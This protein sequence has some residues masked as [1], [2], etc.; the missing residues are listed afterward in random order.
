MTIFVYGDQTEAAKYRSTVEHYLN[1]MTRNFGQTSQSYWRQLSDTAKVHLRLINGQPFA[2]IYTG[3]ALYMESGFLFHLDTQI[4]HDLSYVPSRLYFNSFVSGRTPTT[5]PVPDTALVNPEKTKLLADGDESLA[6]GCKNKVAEFTTYDILGNEYSFSS[7]TPIFCP[8][9][10]DL[11]KAQVS[12]PASVF[13][14]KMRLFIQAIYGSKRTGYYFDET[15][16]PDYPH[17]F[18]LDADLKPVELSSGPISSGLY[19]DPH[20]N[21]WLI[22][23][24]GEIITAREMTTK[25]G[26]SSLNKLTEAMTDPLKEA[27]I[28]GNLTLSSQSQIIG[29]QTSTEGYQAL[30]YGW[31]FNNAGSECSIVVNKEEPNI[32]GTGGLGSGGA[33]VTRLVTLKFGFNEESKLPVIDSEIIVEEGTYVPFQQNRVFIPNYFLSLMINVTVTWPVSSSAMVDFIAP[34]YCYYAKDDTLLVIRAK[35]GAWTE[36]HNLSYEYSGNT[37][38]NS[39]GHSFVNDVNPLF[40]TV[41]G[42]K[43]TVN[44]SGFTAG[45]TLFT[46]TSISQADAEYVANWTPLNETPEERP[47]AYGSDPFVMIRYV[48][49]GDLTGAP[50]YCQTR[51]ASIA[52]TFTAMLII[53]F[54]DAES[55]VFVSENYKAFIP[56]VVNQYRFGQNIVWKADLWSW[57][58]DEHSAI[59]WLAKVDTIYPLTTGPYTAYNFTENLAG[60]VNEITNPALENAGFGDAKSRISQ[61][62]VLLR[63]GDNT[64][65]ELYSESALNPD[66]TVTLK[67]TGM[68]R[69]NIVE[70]YYDYLSTVTAG[71]SSGLKYDLPDIT[72]AIDWPTGTGGFYS[73]SS[74]VG[75]A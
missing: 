44:T 27:Y 59:R 22:K 70:P 73:L 1:E 21:Y 51:F 69:V 38:I 31:K 42:I 52:D 17:L 67:F 63:S 45:E 6:V 33:L 35:N 39:A 54:G 66:F 34:I 4:D 15:R 49:T 47:G 37:E 46:G 16:L 53:P 2:Y 30:A 43:A 62:A 75:W 23:I 28:L 65:L 13:T 36:S 10:R 61:T 9:I 24:E 56:D 50:A 18:M 60:T 5:L 11:K 19:L 12:C 3:A 71:Y 41:E 68:F 72:D 40:S 57:E 29:Q 7:P 8:T 26:R 58:Y 20:N 64:P 14:G 48:Y 32:F 55:V 25:I 74:P